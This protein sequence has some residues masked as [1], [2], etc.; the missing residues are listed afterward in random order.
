MQQ[1]VFF[2]SDAALLMT[3]AV[4]S[5]Q[6]LGQKE[7]DNYS[8]INKAKPNKPQPQQTKNQHTNRGAAAASV[9]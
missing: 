6:T 7:A 8:L 4:M 5:L 9:T 1:D 3:V 2:F